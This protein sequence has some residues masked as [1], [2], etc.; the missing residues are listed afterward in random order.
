[1]DAQRATGR[2][3]GKVAIVFG[4]TYGIGEGIV[5]VLQREGANVVMTG[6]NDEKGAKAAKNIPSAVFIQGDISDLESCHRV[7]KETHERFGMIN[8]VVCN[9]GIFPTAN[10]E[11]MTEEHISSVIDVN[12]KGTIYATKACLP[13]LKESAKSNRGAR[14]IFTSSITGEHTGCRGFGVYGATKS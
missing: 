2:L 4:G 9:A 1:M 7:A 8:I 10:I 3:E 13:Y 6:R 14:L 12:L 5:K 11:D